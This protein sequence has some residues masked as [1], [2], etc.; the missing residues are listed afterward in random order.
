MNNR[1]TL[2]V[3]RRTIIAD[4]NSSLDDSSIA[5]AHSGNTSPAIDPRIA[6]NI[7]T[8]FLD[9]ALRGNRGIA[10]LYT[11]IL[12]FNY[13]RRRFLVARIYYAKAGTRSWEI[14]MVCSQNSVTLFHPPFGWDLISLLPS[15]LS[16]SFVKSRLRNTSPRIISHISLNGLGFV[17]IIFG[18][19]GT[20]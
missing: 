17:M 6:T 15:T 5:L 13:F 1:L 2:F 9:V 14:D 19:L 12:C 20:S 10:L 4:A 18:V 11:T 8:E 3:C 16:L 7:P